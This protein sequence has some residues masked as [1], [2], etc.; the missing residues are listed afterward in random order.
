VEIGS[1][2]QMTQDGDMLARLSTLRAIVSAPAVS[3]RE[4]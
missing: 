3:K 4:D 2:G 1:F